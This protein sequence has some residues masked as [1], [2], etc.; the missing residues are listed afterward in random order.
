MLSIPSKHLFVK[1]SPRTALLLSKNES[2]SRYNDFEVWSEN[3]EAT[4]ASN[5][6]SISAKVRY[7]ENYI[8]GGLF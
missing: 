2:E 5:T 3:V 1:V 4:S 8:G 7:V 6:L